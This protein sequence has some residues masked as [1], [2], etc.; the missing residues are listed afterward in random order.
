VIKI[1]T[2]RFGGDQQASGNLITP[3]AHNLGNDYAA[4]KTTTGGRFV[5]FR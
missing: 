4:A 2:D 5:S 3:K 1:G